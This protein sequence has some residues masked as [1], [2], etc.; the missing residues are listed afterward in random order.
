M[1][2][3]LDATI[4]LGSACVCGGVADASVP[5]PAK[6]AKVVRRGDGVSREIFGRMSS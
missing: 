4:I 1:A 6:D 3:Q 5:F 2:T